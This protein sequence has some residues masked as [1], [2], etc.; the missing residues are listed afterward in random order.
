[1]LIHG[2]GG[3]SEDWRGQLDGLSD[4]VTVV[5]VD[6][7]GHGS[8]EPPGETSVEAYAGW[9]IDLIEALGLE[10]VVVAGCSL[11]GAIA[12]WIALNGKPWLKG[13]GLVGTGARLKVLPDFLEGLYQDRRKAVKMLSSFCVHP[14]ADESVRKMIEE[15]LLTNT[16]DLIHGDLSACNEFDAM[17]R[18]AEISIP[19]WILVGEGDRLTPVKYSQFLNKGIP[20]STL[21]VLEG[22]GH[23]AMVEKPEAFNRFLRGFLATLRG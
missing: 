16:A 21:T 2:S 7:P 19:T 20:G 23:M 9:V 4:L 18:L 8:S 14:D 12:Q 10:K 3:D 15:K 1:V 11:G 22:A 13:I 17:K 6:L 5:A